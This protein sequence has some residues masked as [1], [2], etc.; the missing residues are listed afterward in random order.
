MKRI[1]VA[2]K[3]EPGEILDSMISSLKS[4]LGN[5]SI[6]WTESSNIHITLVFLGNTEDDLVD[7]LSSKLKEQC[8]GLGKFEIVL[9]GAG[10]FKS[11]NDPRVLWAG[12]EPSPQLLQLNER[13]KSC[14]NELNIKI[15]DRPFKPHL[16]IGRIKNVKNKET[17]KSL[18][19]KYQ[20]TEF[21]RIKVNDFILYES[22]LLQR[23]PLYKEISIIDL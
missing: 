10:V 18:V 7:K 6:K 3:I 13:I 1:F 23:G 19:Y 8:E 11:M 16:T 2:V 9:R 20:N 5:D 14:I 17:L 21:Q 12:I 4:G 15:E 22:I